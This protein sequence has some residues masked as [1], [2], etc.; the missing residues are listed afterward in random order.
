MMKKKSGA[1]L[2][3]KYNDIQKEA[4]LATAKSEVVESES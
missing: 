1:E 4:N 2:K 3:D